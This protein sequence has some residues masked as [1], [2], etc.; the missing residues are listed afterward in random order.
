MINAILLGILEGLTEFLPISST[1]HLILFGELL[2]FN[3]DFSKIFDVVIQVGAVFA[4][5]IYFWKQLLPSDF[6]KESLKDFLLLWSKV[7]V[8]VIPAATFGLTL[9]SFIDQYL[10]YP[11]PVAIALI[12]GAIWILLVDNGKERDFSIDNIKELSYQN[13]FKIGCFQVLALIPGM[14]RSAMTI[15]GGLMIGTSRKF[16]AEFSFFMAIPVLGGAGL[17]KLIKYS[18]TISTGDWQLLAVGTFVSFLVSYLVIAVFMQYIKRH[19][20]KIFAY[21]RFILGIA[22]IAM[23]LLLK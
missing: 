7:F 20:F 19:S 6:K 22:V 18:S 2:E 16:A 23:T 14:S 3:G 12:I 4:V 10:F 11:L 1:G 5:V 17:L 15:I 8:G 13:A 21:Y 9:E